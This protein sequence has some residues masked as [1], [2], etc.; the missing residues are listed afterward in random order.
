[1]NNFN[2]EK[3]FNSLTFELL[4]LFKQ[5]AEQNLHLNTTFVFINFH[6]LEKI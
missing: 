1:M 5:K 4:F 6:F 2:L 3:K